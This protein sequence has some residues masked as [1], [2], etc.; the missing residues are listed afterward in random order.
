M[1]AYKILLNN[2]ETGI[3]ESM[4]TL[5]KVYSLIYK[6]GQVTEAVDDSFGI[7]CFDSLVHAKN[8]IEACFGNA[9][10]VALFE[11]EDIGESEIPTFK[12][13]RATTTGLD[14]FYYNVNYNI[15][16][17]EGV[18]VDIPEGTVCYPKVKLLKKIDF[19]RI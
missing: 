6:V 17:N 15:I 5:G 1:K 18:D 7:F 8:Y 2:V 13:S 16:M 12:A 10:H 14:E 4:F 3:Y 11:V 9:K 19:R